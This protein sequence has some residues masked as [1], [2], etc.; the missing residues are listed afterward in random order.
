MILHDIGMIYYEKGDYDI[1][2]KYYQ[3]ALERK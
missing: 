2:I 3:M 1:A